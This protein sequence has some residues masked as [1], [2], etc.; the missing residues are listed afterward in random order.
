MRVVSLRGEPMLQ[1]SV[2]SFEREGW[3]VVSVVRGT[4]G[5][6]TVTYRKP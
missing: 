4:L 6:I 5:R 1:A 2:E 3:E